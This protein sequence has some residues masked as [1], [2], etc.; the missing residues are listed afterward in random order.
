MIPVVMDVRKYKWEKEKNELMD[1]AAHKSVLNLRNYWTL[2]IQKQIRRKRSLNI[3]E[4][5]KGLVL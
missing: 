5:E 3:L 2:I 4:E 1:K